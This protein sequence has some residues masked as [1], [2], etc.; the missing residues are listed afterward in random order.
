LRNGAATTAGVKSEKEVQRSA[1][2]AGVAAVQPLEGLFS[3][4]FFSC[5]MKPEEGRLPVLTPGGVV[6]LGLLLSASDLT[7]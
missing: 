7:E 6:G 3:L 1:S 2:P 4:F 5:T